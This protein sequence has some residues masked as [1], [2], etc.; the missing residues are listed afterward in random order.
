[1]LFGGGGIWRTDN[2]YATPEGRP[3]G[4]TWRSVTDDLPNNGGSMA[5]GAN[6]NI[7]YY[8]IGESL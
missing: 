1:V 5:F 6:G 7:L 8:G 3:G 2:F 4:T